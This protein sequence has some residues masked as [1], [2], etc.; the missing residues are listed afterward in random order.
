M[1]KAISFVLITLLLYSCA[2]YKQ[3]KPQPDI[4]PQENGFIEIKKDSKYFK[5][6]KDK[7]YYM[8]FPPATAPN[9]YLVLDIANKDLI[10][11]YL[12]VTFDQGKGRIIEIKDESP[13]PDHL[14]VY[15]ISNDVPR[16]YWVIDLVK[17][18]MVLDMHYRYVA[19]WRFKFERHYNAF[20]KTLEE[21]SVERTPYESLGVNVQP[22]DLNLD[23][24]IS[25]IRTKNQ[26]L[27]KLKKELK[28]IEDIFPVNIRNTSDEAYQNFI[29]LKEQLQDE[30]KFQDHYLQVLNLLKKERDSR[31]N[32]E[33]FLS[34]IPDFQKFFDSKDQFPNNVVM[35]VRELLNKRLQQVVPYYEQKLKA[36]N[37]A[38]RIESAIP[39]LEK[40]YP[41]AGLTMNDDFK[42]LGAFVYA[43]NK[44]VD[45][46][47][48]VKKDLQAIRNRVKKQKKMPSN[49]FFSDIVTQ[50]SKM[51]YT[52]PRTNVPAF[53][54][55]RTYTCVKKLD[56]EIKRTQDIINTMLSKYR[57]ADALVPEINVLKERNNLRSILKLLKKNKDLDFLL[58][59]YSKL[60]QESLNKQAQAIRNALQSENWA[61]AD[62][63]LKNLYNDRNF[64]N[65]A[66][67]KPQKIKL[68]K[69]ME[70]ALI[71]AIAQRSKERAKQ[72][73]Q[74]N[75]NTL[76][77]VE[78]LYENPAFQPVYQPSFFVPG[79]NAKAQMQSLNT[80]LNAIKTLSFPK[81]AIEHLYKQ[82]IANP[83]NQGVL[84]ARAIVV[85]GKHYRG[86]DVTVK[87]RVAECDPQIP[88]LLTK[89]RSYRR[90]FALPVTLNPN[91]INNYLFKIN[92]KI[93]SPAQYPVFDVYIRLPQDL[94]KQANAKQWYERITFNGKVIKNEGRYTITAPGPDNNYE[95]QIGPLQ[96]V[97]TSNNILEIRFKKAGLHVYQVSVMAQ[98]PIIKK[99]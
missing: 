55:Y 15:P 46:V 89:P 49:S 50:L 87:N 1:N 72:F 42:R 99:H 51:L 5:L 35:A 44:I 7:K 77:N 17:Q 34:A 40:L 3:L 18:D 78:A 90:I 21:N 37:D 68:A 14:A 62:E 39:Q 75:L 8:I 27:L 81:A 56:K 12:T 67:I 11:S 61:L 47:W 93:P 38:K 20:K 29:S 84:K 23:Q 98:K 43:Y 25:A 96:I 13:E 94:A 82:L 95:C 76:E 16:Y 83:D 9:D 64:I 70:N 32:T 41:A 92:L 58:P 31:N 74:E 57:R 79:T 85:H 36:K 28:Q 10:N 65:Y 60:D 48:K 86:D 52:L 53:Q 59:M 91:G 97:K 26:N 73:M 24:Q 63:A 30:L 71:Q 6:K 19:R 54:P 22:Q 80:A 4:N 45:N 33:Q 2:A 88:K 66:K 69:E